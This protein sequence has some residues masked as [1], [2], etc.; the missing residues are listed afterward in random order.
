MNALFSVPKRTGYPLDTEGRKVRPAAALARPGKGKG[1]PGPAFH[2]WVG[3]G[4][5]GFFVV[6]FFVSVFLTV[7]AGAV[8]SGF[9]TTKSSL[10]STPL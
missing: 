2:G 10:R 3:A 4:R 9:S 1:G 6:V 7:L 8:P 5:Y